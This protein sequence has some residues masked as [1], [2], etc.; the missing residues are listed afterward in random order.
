MIR[1]TA[2]E[3][4]FTMMALNMLEAGKTTNNMDLARSTGLTEPNTKAIIRQAKKM[5]M[6]NSYGL[7]AR[8][9]KVIL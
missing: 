4:T 6:A 9:I 7:T 3:S 5:D 8:H 1:L 2:K